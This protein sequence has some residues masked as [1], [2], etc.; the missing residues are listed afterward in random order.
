MLSSTKVLLP[1]PHKFKKCSYSSHTDK[2][3]FRKS[4][5]CLCHSL[6]PVFEYKDNKNKNEWKQQRYSKRSFTS[7]SSSSSSSSQSKKTQIAAGTKNHILTILQFGKYP[8]EMAMTMAMILL[9]MGR[10]D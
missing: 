1:S 5:N 4:I 7:S 6:I 9:G 8:S 10:N 2:H 3:Q